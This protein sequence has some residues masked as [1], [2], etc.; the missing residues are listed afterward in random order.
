[1]S[2][3]KPENDNNTKSQKEPSHTVSKSSS[4]FKIYFINFIFIFSELRYKSKSISIE[5]Q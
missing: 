5:Q 2:E 3:L 4:K 1:M